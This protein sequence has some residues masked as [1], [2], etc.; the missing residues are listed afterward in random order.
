MI[1]KIQLLQQ[2]LASLRVVREPTR[3]GAAAEAAPGKREASAPAQQAEAHRMPLD[4]Q[5][6]R[7]AAAIDKDDPQRRRRLLRATLEICLCAEW[8]DEMAADPAFQALVDRVQ[9]QIEGDPS[10]QP[11]VDDALASLAP[12]SFP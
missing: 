10:L 4:E 3:P 5:I 12:P 9:Q 11:V 8:G 6:R 1:P 7:R 2:A